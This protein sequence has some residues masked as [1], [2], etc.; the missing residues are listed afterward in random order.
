MLDKMK[1]L[2]KKVFFTGKV[3]FISTI[4]FQQPLTKGCYKNDILTC[5]MI[6]IRPC[7]AHKMLL[8][9]CHAR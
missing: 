9:T 4:C 5:T 8:D 3:A 1:K 7:A 2:A 6:A